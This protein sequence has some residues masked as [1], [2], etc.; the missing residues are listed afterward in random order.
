LVTDPEKDFERLVGPHGQCAC[1]QV[2]AS[3]EVDRG[4][5]SRTPAP[6][7]RQR[8]PGASDFSLFGDIEGKLFNYNDK[9]ESREDLLNAITEIFIGVDGVGK[10]N[11]AGRSKV[12]C[13]QR[14]DRRQKDPNLKSWY[15]S[16]PASE[17]SW[18]E[19]IGLIT[20][21]EVIVH[22]I[23]AGEIADR[24]R[25]AKQVITSHL[26]PDYE[27]YSRVSVPPRSVTHYI[28]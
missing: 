26:A 25:S 16:I 15:R 5:R 17:G 20:D 19:S 12:A 7:G 6:S 28:K 2:G 21:V 13:G 27:R 3:S 14:R 18:I 8:R 9:C 24:T 1:S 23:E 10:L 11:R 22:R 4:L